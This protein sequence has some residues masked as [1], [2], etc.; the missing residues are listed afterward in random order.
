MNT[1]H[2]PSKEEMEL[3]EKEAK[4]RSEK[5][6]R[7]AMFE[8]GA[9]FGYTLGAKSSD[10]EIEKLRVRLAACGV[11][12]L[13][14]TESTVKE[15]ITKDNEFWCASYQD[16]CNAVDREIDCREKLRVVVRKVNE[17]QNTIGWL[18]KG[19]GTV[20][21]SVLNAW[22]LNA[23]ILTELGEYQNEYLKL[24]HAKLDHKGDV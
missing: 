7:Q 1:P 18:A 9:L 8:A 5:I 6:D 4:A 2:Q 14:N 16:V 3:I 11:A 17:V 10:A 23:Q 13:M 15:R 22:N 24:S 20:G 21:D 12:A 19:S